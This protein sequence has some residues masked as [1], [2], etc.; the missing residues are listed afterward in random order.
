MGS[1]RD[2]RRSHVC[3][4]AYTCCS[5]LRARLCRNLC[6]ELYLPLSTIRRRRAV[7][8]SHRA[9]SPQPAV[10]PRRVLR[11][12][13]QACDDGEGVVEPAGHAVGRPAALRT[14][15]VGV[16]LGGVPDQII[17]GLGRE[18]PS[19]ARPF[20]RE[21]RA[22]WDAR[23]AEPLAAVAP[24]RPV[25][26]LARHFS[27]VAALAGALA[28]LVPIRQAL[29][30]EA[31]AAPARAAIG[32]R[33]LARV[34]VDARVQYVQPGAEVPPWSALEAPP[35]STPCEPGLVTPTVTKP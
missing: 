24:L 3:A 33:R 28:W 16:T 14:G 6:P 35:W 10:L 29:D 31:N 7:T 15:R 34:A 32:A 19:L 9:R 27:R 1:T 18:P 21:R 25:A 11:E 8:E 26:K 20:S 2:A 4:P 12:L 5:E 22:S 30:A 13:Q 17:C 23:Y